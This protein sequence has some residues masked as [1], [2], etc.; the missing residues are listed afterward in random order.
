MHDHRVHELGYVG[1]DVQDMAGWRRFTTEIV[2]LS[3]N[4]RNADGS[5][6]LGMDD[7]HHRVA[8]RE[9]AED[10]IAYAGWKV[11]DADALKAVRDRLE[12]LGAP[13]RR[14]TD[15]EAAARGARALVRTQDPDGLT[16][17]VSWGN[18]RTPVPFRASRE[19]GGGFVAGDHGLGH[20]VLN[21]DDLEASLAFFRDGLGL[22]MSDVIELDTGEPTPTTVAFLHCGPRHHSLALAPFA[23]TKRL[24]HVMFEV[25]EAD[26]V[27][28]AYDRCLDL[29]VPIA[30]T[31]GRHTNDRMTSFY[32]VTPSGFQVEYGHGGVEVDD[33]TW[34]VRTYTEAS[35][36]GHRS[37]L[38]S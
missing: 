16:H 26:D 23:H 20:I 25:E 36:W 19:M 12:D 15:E 9:G 3:D 33:A 14:A 4:G 29:G 32:A 31:L 21:V 34:E 35:T 2:G 10:D 37:P 17:E 24:H 22:R 18:S 8:V 38:P 1:L 30:A 27:G 7:A 28:T 13:V 5:V 11:S 6:L